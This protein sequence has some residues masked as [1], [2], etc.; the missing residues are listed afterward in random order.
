MADGD[1]W[2]EIGRGGRLRA[3]R[4]DAGGGGGRFG[5]GGGN[6]GGQGGGGQRQAPQVRPRPRAADIRARVEARPN[7]VLLNCHRFQVLPTE[8]QV[9]EWFGDYLFTGDVATLLG[10]VTGL[11]IEEREKRIMVQL[12]S[13]Q[14]VELLLTRMGEEG[15]EWP[16]FV[17]PETNQPIK[18]R[19]YSTDKS[20]LRLTLLDV[21]RDVEDE[22]IR[23]ALAQYGTVEEVKRHHLP[24]PGMEHIKVNRVSVKLAKDKEVEL[25]T[26]IFGLGSST[27][28]EER[29]IWKVTYPG[30]PKR[31]YRCGN[32]NHMARDCRRPSI[33]MQ[34]VESMPALGEERTADLD[35]EKNLH[36]PRSFAAVVK[37]PKFLEAAVMQEQEA[38]RLKHEKQAKKEAEE[39]KREEDKVA[40]ARAKA[41]MAA[42]KEQ[43]EEA[44]RAAHLAELAK[45]VEKATLHN[46]YVKNL[47]AQAQAQMKE[48]SE[49]EREMEEMNRPGGDGSKRLAT[50]PA[51]AAPQA[52]KPSTSH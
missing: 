9:A 45:T 33:T 35:V 16:G 7:T 32:A 27:S 46:K 6:G 1:G 11:D 47:H 43:L 15:V 44:K 41:E 29:S 8:V 18:I 31:C 17:D 14:E 26:T 37:S 24:K 38:A 34:Q 42:E 49:Y 36:F 22:T 28:G 25:P 48:T 30:A 51:E 21:P 52:K 50:S 39:K 12:S 19:G 13:S 10:K 20:S 40:K 5:T 23:M 2:R 3:P 4:S